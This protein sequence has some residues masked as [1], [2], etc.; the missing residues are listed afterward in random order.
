MAETIYSYCFLIR[1]NLLE[2]ELYISG[3]LPG[4]MDGETQT[5][6]SI[7]DWPRL[8]QIYFIFH[9]IFPNNFDGWT[10]ELG[11]VSPH[12]SLTNICLTQHH[13]KSKE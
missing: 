3:Q 7:V 1:R 4:V 11:T 12:L 2:I 13:K 9:F 10:A 8:S 6:N 5:I